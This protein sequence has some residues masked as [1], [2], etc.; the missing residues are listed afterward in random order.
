MRITEVINSRIFRIGIIITFVL[1]LLYLS[2]RLFFFETDP[3]LPFIDKVFDSWLNLSGR[4]ANNLFDVFNLNY[5]IEGHSLFFD[6]RL[7]YEYSNIFLMRKIFFG[8]LIFFWLFPIKVQ[9]KIIASVT[10]FLLHLFVTSVDMVILANMLTPTADNSESAY[11]VSRTPGVMIIVTLFVGWVLIFKEDIYRGLRKFKIDTDFIDRK[12][13]DLFVIIYLYVFIGNFLLGWYDYK[14]WINFLFLTSQEI[15]SYLDYG[16]IVY[17]TYLLGENGGIYMEKGCLG[18]GTMMLFAA[19]VYL[20]S[21]KGYA[22]W[23]YMIAGLVFLNIINITRFVFLFI[24][25]E[26]NSGYAMSMDV[27][28]M[29]NLILYAV[30]FVLWVVWFEF[31]ALKSIDKGKRPD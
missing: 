22:R 29:Y 5:H 27:H 6:N 1:G 3:L 18:F 28:D 20:T 31:F 21:E 10:L 8:V 4:I 30:V 24:H 9:Y 25:I 14:G 2:L 26:Q 19:V 11:W 16:S 12:L 13:P 17:K 7:L 15:L 23:I